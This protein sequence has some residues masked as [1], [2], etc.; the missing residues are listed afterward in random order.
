M[1]DLASPASLAQCPEHK[2]T[3]WAV[4]LLLCTPRGGDRGARRVTAR[5]H[6][7]AVEEKEEKQKRGPNLQH[8]PGSPKRVQWIYAPGG[9]GAEFSLPGWV[10]GATGDRS[11]RMQPVPM[12][13]SCCVGTAQGPTT[14]LFCSDTPVGPGPG[15]ETRPRCA[16]TFTIRTSRSSR[17]LSIATENQAESAPLPPALSRSRVEGNATR[18]VTAA[19]LRP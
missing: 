7:Q 13:P 3:R 18:K 17:G 4:A 1:K 6:G 14:W 8:S 11:K 9:K 12:S 2:G 10:I 19:Q 16:E 5:R 15:W